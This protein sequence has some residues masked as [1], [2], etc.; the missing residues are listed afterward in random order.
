MNHEFDLSV[1][2]RHARMIGQRLLDDLTPSFQTI[3]CTIFSLFS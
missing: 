2:V 1:R 3:H